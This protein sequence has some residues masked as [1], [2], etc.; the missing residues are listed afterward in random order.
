MALAAEGICGDPMYVLLLIF[1]VFLYLLDG[2]ILD[3][4][5]I[6]N[7][8]N[9]SCQGASYNIPQIVERLG[10]LSEQFYNNFLLNLNA[11]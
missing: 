6:D 1:S 5:S 2:S 10:T 11:K 4:G 3:V 7:I 9:P 8:L